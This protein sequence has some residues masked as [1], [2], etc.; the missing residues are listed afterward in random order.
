[1]RKDI[2]YDEM[3]GCVEKVNSELV[4]KPEQVVPALERSFNWG[5]T[6]ANNVS[7]AS[8]RRYRGVEA[9]PATCYRFYDIDVANKVV[10]KLYRDFTGAWD[11]PE[12]V[13][14]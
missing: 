5:R 13:L 2:R 11:D 14:K 12:K 1:M 9:I 10:S 4:T 8:M 3:F 6:A 7:I